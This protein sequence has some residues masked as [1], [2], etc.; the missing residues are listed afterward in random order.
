[1]KIITPLLNEKT[2]KEK[3]FQILNLSVPVLMGIYIFFNPFPHTTAIKDTCFYFGAGIAILLLVLKKID[4]SFRLPLTLPFILF[5]VW[6]VIGLFFALD[7]GNSIHDFFVHLLKY[8]I[9]YYVMVNTYNSR[10]RINYL[11]WIII[12]S[13]SIFSF[14][15]I[16]YYYVMLKYPLSA[17]LM[18]GL[19][20]IPVNLIGVISITALIFALHTALHNNNTYSVRIIAT[21]CSLPLFAIALLSQSRGTLTA[22]LFATTLLLAKNKKTLAIFILVTIGIASLSPVKDRFLN[23]NVTTALRMGIN[24]TSLEVLKDFPLLGIGFGMETY[25]NG[26]II[27]LKTFNE[28]VPSKYQQHYIHNDPHNMLMSVAVRTGVIG[29]ILY[30][31]ILY[32]FAK[33]CWMCIR[34]GKDDF[35]K[36][37]GICI[38]AA[39]TAV[40]IIGLF[41]PVFSHAPETV[42]FTLFAMITIIWRI[43]LNDE[44]AHQ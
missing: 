38:A 34:H 36:K 14:G 42:L 37:W 6:V 15:C 22:M 1:L 2:S 31:F 7:R 33:T 17:K 44:E 13:A 30:L 26:K 40:F 35:I 43:N 11:S 27:D 41:E 9:F 32:T 25:R 24:Y 16:F 23:P 19:P 28:R 29:L 8:I 21:C 18:L 10:R 3:I 20:E 39:F 4:F 12:T 5:V